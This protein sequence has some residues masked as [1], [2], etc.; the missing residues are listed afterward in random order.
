M[1]DGQTD[2]QT[3]GP[4]DRTPGLPRSDKNRLLSITNGNRVSLGVKCQVSKT[5]ISDGGIAE[6]IVKYHKKVSRSIIKPVSLSKRIISDEGIEKR[7]VKKYQGASLNRYHYQRES[8]V[9]RA[10]GDERKVC[11]QNLSYQL[12][13]SSQ[14]D[15]SQHLKQRHEIQY[16]QSGTIAKKRN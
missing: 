4:K 8:Q 13:A 14:L 10:L 2:G 12:S 1:C 11:R 16:L 7:I 15:L 3:D 6:I 5:I 9:M